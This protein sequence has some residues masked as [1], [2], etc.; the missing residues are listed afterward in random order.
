MNLRLLKNN[1]NLTLLLL[2]RFVSGLGAGVQQFAFSLYVLRLTGSAT[3]FASVLVAGMIPSLF[4]GPIC[5]VFADWFD[6]KKIIVYLDLLSG[7]LYGGMYFISITSPS[8]LT[9]A[10]IY[11]TVIATSIIASLFNPAINSAIPSIVEKDDLMEANSFNRLLMTITMMISPILAGALYPLGI[12]II[13]L[14]NSISFILSAISEAFIDLKSPNK[15]TDF[16]L[17]AFKNDFKTGVSFILNHKMIRKIISL[18]FVANAFFAPVLTIGLMFIASE[19]LKV[20]EIQ[21]GA[22]NSSL[23]VGSMFGAVIAGVVGKK[24]PLYKTISAALLLMGL[25]VCLIGFASLPVFLDIFSSN[26]VPYLTIITLSVIIVTATVVTNVGMAT[27]M[28]RE[29]PIE[30]MGRV[31]SVKETAS[32]CATPVGQLLFAFLMDSTGTFIP[33]IISGTVM[34]AGATL[35]NYSVSK[36]TLQENP[37]QPT[38]NPA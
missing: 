4:L 22:L 17:G 36:E 1:K 23:M 5:G 11:F 21:I 38:E 14:L 28:Q 26:L 30:I 3:Y 19:V 16:S 20:S 35:F 2:G 25:F 18:S 8:S 24:F 9:M 6:R 31:S 33:I 15:K 7:L 34:I 12:S 27:L 32:M 13:L 37:L 29:V 10:H